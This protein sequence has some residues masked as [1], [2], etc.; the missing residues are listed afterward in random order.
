MLRIQNPEMRYC[1]RE[2]GEIDGFKIVD[3]RMLNDGNNS[4]EEYKLNIER[5][6]SWL[7]D[8]T[9]VIVCYDYR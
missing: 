8:N 5:V 1:N 7:R 2:I 6:L 3:V 9:N 4:L